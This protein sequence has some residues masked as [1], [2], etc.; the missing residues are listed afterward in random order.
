MSNLRGGNLEEMRLMSKM[1]SENAGKLNGIISVL[2]SRT[3]GS[4]HIWTGPAA[5]RFR[6][7]WSEARA[8]FEKMRLALDEASTAVN[9]SAQN[10]ETA[11]R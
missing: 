3:A 7:A 11:T 5:D 10:I 2:N 4:E 1:F 6:T 9:K 8:S